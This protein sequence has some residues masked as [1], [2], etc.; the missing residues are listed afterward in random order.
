MNDFRN[1]VN[2]KR[3]QILAAAVLLLCAGL[4]VFNDSRDFPTVLREPTQEELAQQERDSKRDA[5]LWDAE[6]NH[7][8]R[9]KYECL[10]RKLYTPLCAEILRINFR[11]VNYSEKYDIAFDHY[12][13]ERGLEQASTSV[14][15]VRDFATFKE[16]CTCTLPK[17]KQDEFDN[18][19]LIAVSK[20][21]DQY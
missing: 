3:F 12:I 6:F 10:S 20:C 15:A 1:F 2:K 5:C 21:L 16:S 14:D 8:H 13:T 7:D 18:K 17:D 4:F 19:R 9:V 11:D